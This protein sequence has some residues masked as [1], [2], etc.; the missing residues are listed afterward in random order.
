VLDKPV[1]P[2]D[3]T[4]TIY[5]ALGIPADLMLVDIDVSL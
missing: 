5:H 1:S 2:A 4:A 3:L